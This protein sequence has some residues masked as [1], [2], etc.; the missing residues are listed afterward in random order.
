MNVSVSQSAACKCFASETELF[1]ALSEMNSRAYQCLYDQCFG[2]VEWFITKNSGT[3]D[4]AADY[5]QNGMASLC[6]NVA[7][8]S[9][10]LRP[11]VKVS[12][13]L[14][15]ICRRQWLAYLG[16]KQ[17]KTLV[18]S[19]DTSVELADEIPDTIFEELAD[20]RLKNLSQALENL[21]ETCQQIIRLFYIEDRSLKEIA[22]QLNSTEGTVKVSRF[23]CVEQL[24]KHF[25]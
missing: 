17:Y 10:V 12:T 9:F 2:S 13:Y 22:Q 20:Y 14:I 5:F 19:Q 24:K 4:D 8:G 11:N 18:M 25:R 7:N 1:N 16:S 6:V 21:G 3:V 15:E 23:R